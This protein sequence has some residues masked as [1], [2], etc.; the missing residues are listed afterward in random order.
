MKN[1]N[2]EKET[3]LSYKPTNTIDFWRGTIHLYAQRTAPEFQI[4][5]GDEK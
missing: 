5:R 3:K 1:I 4:Q 2:K